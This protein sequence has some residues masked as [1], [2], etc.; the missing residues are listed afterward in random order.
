MP[1]NEN[2]VVR[3]KFADS[4]QNTG[5]M[6]GVFQIIDPDEGTISPVT[7][8]TTIP[9]GLVEKPDTTLCGDGEHWA[10]FILE[11]YS[12]QVFVRLATVSAPIK[13][14]TKLSLN[15][16]GKVVPFDGSGATFTVARTLEPVTTTAPN[17][18]VRSI[19][20][21][22]PSAAPSA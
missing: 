5:E 19:L 18:L 22:R 12:G 13:E 7:N 15:A 2:S 9:D 1:A 8:N 14:M 4:V 11:P 20:Y 3:R 6:E 10:N 21:L 16:E 17:Q